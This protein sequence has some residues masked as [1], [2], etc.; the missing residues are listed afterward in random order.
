MSKQ[1]L[2]LVSNAMTSLGIEYDFVTYKKDPVIY[3]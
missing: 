1:V 2:K 3:P